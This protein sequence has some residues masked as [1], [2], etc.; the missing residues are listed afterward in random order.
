MKSIISVLA[1]AVL[2]L[3]L[4]TACGTSARTRMDE[5]RTTPNNATVMPAATANANNAAA[6]GTANNAANKAGNTVGNAAR[7]AGDVVGNAVEDVG[8]TVGNAAKGAGNAVDDLFNGTDTNNG[9]GLEEP[10]ATAT[11]KP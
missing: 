10:R 9:A 8:N 4:L 2:L 11:A 3:S 1:S 6:N 5:A 7:D